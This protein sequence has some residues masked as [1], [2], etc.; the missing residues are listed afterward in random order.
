ME[1]VPCPEV[2]VQP[3]GTF[4]TYP[5]APE[6]AGIEYTNPVATG[7][8]EFACPAAGEGVAGVAGGPVDTATAN[9][10]AALV[11]QEFPDVTEILPFAAVPVVDTVMLVVPWPE[12]IV[13]PVGTVHV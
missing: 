3:A 6:T 2:I 4:Q 11:P 8:I 9:A 7:Q 12:V 1:V 10:W 5:V 13:H